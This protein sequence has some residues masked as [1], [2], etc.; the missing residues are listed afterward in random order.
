VAGLSPAFVEVRPYLV[1]SSA[2]NLSPEW[3]AGGIVSSARDLVRWARAIRDGELL[4]PEMQREV[5]TY[6]PPEVPRRGG[7]R[8][9]QGIAYSE[10]FYGNRAVYGHSGGTLGFT[11]YMYWLDGTD[12]I[13]V[14]LA[15][16]GGMHSGLSPGPVSLYF[17]Q[18]WLPAVMRYLRR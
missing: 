6:H 8:Y 2:G 15:N 16:V 17:R 18:V 10:G 1:D 13:V 9:L 12:I 3:T 14:L 4:G 7:S 5:F 11:A